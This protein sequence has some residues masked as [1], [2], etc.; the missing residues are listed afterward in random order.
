MVE[1][2]IVRG[3]SVLHAPVKTSLTD[4]IAKVSETKTDTPTTEEETTDE[5]STDTET[6]DGEGDTSDSVLEDTEAGD[7]DADASGTEPDG[8]VFEVKGTKVPLKD[9]LNAYETR[10]E[11]SKRFNE[12]GKKEQKLQAEKERSKKE[13]E[14]LDFINEKFEEMHELV[15]Q[16]NPMQALQIALSM[17]PKDS[18]Q[19]KAM[20]E[21][22][23]QAVTIAENFQNMTEEEQKLFLEKEELTVKERN[24]K[25]K[26]DKQKALEAEKELK[27]FY[28]TT[29]EA[30][31]ISDSEVELAVEDINK[32]PQFK[33]VLE[34]KTDLKERITYVTSW[35]LGQRL[36][37]TILEGIKKVDVKLSEDNNFRLALL[38]HVDPRCTVE[39]VEAI[40]RE[41]KKPASKDSATSESGASKQDVAS[42][43]T[44]TPNRAPT[45][46]PKVEDKKPITKW[47]DIVAK[48]SA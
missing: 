21:L 24:L 36:N 39:D 26:E 20:K 6:T 47:A 23:E 22:I 45:G 28:D 38:E 29:L 43:K 34:K 37:K 11:I 14:E 4:F 10:E 17:N 7:T 27:T 2:N 44:T 13:R 18:S 8:Q 32:Y 40:V 33:E 19:P 46:K 42:K 48:H 5:T 35:V 9:L 31:K 12:V 25:R 16:G 30:N 1:N 3:D 15:L 41:Y